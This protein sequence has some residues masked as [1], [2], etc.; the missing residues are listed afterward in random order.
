PVSGSGPRK[1][2]GDSSRGW[3]GAVDDASSTAAAGKVMP[4][5]GHLTSSP[6]SPSGRRSFRQQEGHSMK[7]GMVVTHLPHP[8]ARADRDKIAALRH[9][10]QLG[11]ACSGP[12]KTLPHARL[13]G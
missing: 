11:I 8:Q 7:S 4:H 3:D 1:V 9:P 5:M 2:G 13:F 10:W 12:P 6:A